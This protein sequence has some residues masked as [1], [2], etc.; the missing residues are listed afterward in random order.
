M[1]AGLIRSG[2]YFRWKGGQPRT[3][4]VA[5]ATEVY[6][7]EPLLWTASRSPRRSFA[8]LIRR[9]HRKLVNWRRAIRRPPSRNVVRDARRPRKS[10]PAVKLF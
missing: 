4:S 7:D 3:M 9:T 6:S 1:Q 8:L 10:P 5:R 2:Q